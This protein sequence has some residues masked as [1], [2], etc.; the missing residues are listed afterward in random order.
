MSREY[1]PKPRV[2]VVMCTWNRPELFEMTVDCL[3]QQTGVVPVLYVWN[4]NLDNQQHLDKVAASSRLEIVIHHH[5]ENIGGFGRFY[6][7]KKL[8]DD[9]EYVVFIDDDQVF[10]PD[11]LLTLYAEARPRT[12]YGWWAFQFTSKTPSYWF[13]RRIKPGQR[14]HY[15]GTCG[16]I[17]DASIFK[18]ERLYECPAEFWFIE[19][20]WLCFIANHVLGWDLIATSAEFEAVLDMKNQ[21]PGLLTKKTK[22]L[23]HLVKEGWSIAS[24]RRNVRG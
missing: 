16:M 5:H 21:A 3:E 24:T 8:A 13:R 23:R 9:N 14:A 1:H 19:D 10:G 12:V 2:I 22:L 20:L 4:N 18:D 7:A 17:V 11:T 6:Q 15:I